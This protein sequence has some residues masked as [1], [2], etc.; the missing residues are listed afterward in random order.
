MIYFTIYQVMILSSGTFGQ[1]ESKFKWVY[2]RERERVG[3]VNHCLII[4]PSSFTQKELRKFP[5][6]A[7]YLRLQCDE[8]AIMIL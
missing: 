7:F 5:C 3:F 8:I 6:L 1:S 2:K 4:N